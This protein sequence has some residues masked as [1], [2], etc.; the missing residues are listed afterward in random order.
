MKDRVEQL[1]LGL[2]AVFSILV[3]VLDWLRLLPLPPGTVPSLTLLGVGLITGYLVLERRSKLDNIEQLIINGSERIIRSLGGVNVR[4]FEN[5]QDVYEYAIKRMKEA[6]TS[7]DDLT[8]GTVERER[9]VAEK[10]AYEKYIE[11]ISTVCSSKKNI[12]YR[13]V[14]SFPPLRHIDRAKSILQKNLCGYKLRFF[15]LRGEDLPASFCLMW[16]NV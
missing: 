7:I 1:I 4:R 6:K 8:W 10:Q 2:S 15:Q 5:R 11:T 12:I 14:M 3:A 13:E 16:I 9:T